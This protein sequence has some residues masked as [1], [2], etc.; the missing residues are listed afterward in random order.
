MSSNPTPST[1][2]HTWLKL[3]KSNSGATV[4]AG[5]MA[6]VFAVFSAI[7]VAVYQGLTSGTLHLPPALDPYAPWVIVILGAIIAAV[8]QSGVPAY[9]P[10]QTAPGQP[11]PT[12][13]A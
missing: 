8:V 1:H 5:L 4:G 10:G 13:K 6:V 12:P 9:H 2:T 11:E 7:A 3:P